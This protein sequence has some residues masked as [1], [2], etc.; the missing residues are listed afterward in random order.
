M[1]KTKLTASDALVTLIVQGMQEKKATG[2][3]VMDLRKLKSAVTDYFVICS[4]NSDTQVDAIK[5]SVYEEVKKA[6]G[7]NPWQQEGQQ[8]REWVLIDYV[9]V[10]VHIFRKDRRKFYALEDL[11]GD[12]ELTEIPD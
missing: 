5:D 6:I 1:R 12:A 2:I 3:T 10:V 11:W 9:D 4:A 8:N 7:Q